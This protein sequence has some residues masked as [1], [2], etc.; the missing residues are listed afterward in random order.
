MLWFMGFGILWLVAF[1]I[2]CAQFIII[3]A[4]CT[5]YFS[6]ESDT[7]GKASIMTGA[8]WIPRY[9]LGSLAFGSLIVAIV[10]TIRLL[11]EYFAVSFSLNH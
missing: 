4:S 11:F 2:A 5:W 1:L 8:Y 3:V 9:H 6:K 7:S 10:W